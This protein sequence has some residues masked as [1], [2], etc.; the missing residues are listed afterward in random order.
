MTA[1]E[2][3]IMEIF[4]AQATIVVLGAVSI[5]AAD[6]LYFGDR[7]RHSLHSV[8]VSCSITLIYL[9]VVAWTST[10]FLGFGALSQMFDGILGATI[11]LWVYRNLR[12]LTSVQ[13]LGHGL[14][15][16]R[17]SRGQTPHHQDLTAEP[18]F[19]GLSP[20]NWSNR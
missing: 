15:P 16:P 10:V 5:G 14:F 4:I 11:F 19:R 9:P 3:F 20:R 7:I 13:E 1:N 2:M 12:K 18:G 6:R 8:W 17:F